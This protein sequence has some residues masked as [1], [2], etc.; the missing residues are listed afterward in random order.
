MRVALAFDCCTYC[1]ILHISMNTQPR[2]NPGVSFAVVGNHGGATCLDSLESNVR[3]RVKA[4][5]D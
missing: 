2:D 5:V 1:V 4:I 3:Y